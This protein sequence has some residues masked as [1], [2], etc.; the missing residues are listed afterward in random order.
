[1]RPIVARPSSPAHRISNFVDIILK[2]LCKEVPSFLRDDMDFLNH[3]P[4]E[5]NENTFLVSFDV[6][7]LYT[8]IPHDLGLEA[9]VC[10]LQNHNTNLKRPFTKEFMLKAISLI[11][12]EN[13]FQFN[14]KDY[15]QIQGTA[16]GTEMAP[17]YATLVMGYLEKQLYVRYEE[18]YGSTERKLFIKLFKRFLDD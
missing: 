1:M 6:V 2:P 11:L 15:K 7:S 16:M 17:T 10:W 12:K 8:N 3:M 4:S 14:D 9:I 13:T 5:I 18:I